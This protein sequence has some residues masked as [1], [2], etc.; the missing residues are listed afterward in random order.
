MYVYVYIYIYICIYTRTLK[1]SLIPGAQP[2]FVAD[3][4]QPSTEMSLKNSTR[5]IRFVRVTILLK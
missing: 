2:L 5:A 1:V 4:L 3:P